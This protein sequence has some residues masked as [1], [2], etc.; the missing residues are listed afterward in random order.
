M[1]SREEKRFAAMVCAAL[2]L[3]ILAGSFVHPATVA[4][5]AVG[6]MLATRVL[7]WQD[8]TGH[9]PAWDMLVRLATLVTL[10]DGLSRTGFLA[11]FA[12]GVS[13]QLVGLPPLVAMTGLVAL[14]FV[15]H[16]LFA[17][18]TAH[19]TAVMPIVLG[20]GLATPAIPAL[21]FAMLLAFS[22]GLMGV[23]SPYATG[24]APVFHGSGFLPG[25][26]FWRLGAVFGALFLGALLLLGTPAVLLLG[27]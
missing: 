18:T 16:Y 27:R 22:H 7:G 21:P 3:W 1:P 13:H 8:V 15:S 12:H 17:T 10:A 11:W 5:A 6:L 14:Y 4:L 20:V 25:P 23:I 24:P 26:L 19:A 9:R 2:A